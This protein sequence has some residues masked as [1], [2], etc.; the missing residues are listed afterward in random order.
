MT[1][2]FRPGE[3]A[4]YPRVIFLAS[5]SPIRGTFHMRFGQPATLLRITPT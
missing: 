5:V 4:F 1:Q 3:L 2:C